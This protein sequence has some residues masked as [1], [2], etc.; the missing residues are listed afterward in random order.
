MFAP[1]TCY[2][3]V[4][5]SRNRYELCHI[6]RVEDTWNDARKPPALTYTAAMHG[7][8]VISYTLYLSR[9]NSV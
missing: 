4:Q 1:M 7:R 8:I 2:A 6:N 3:E 9:I 5:F